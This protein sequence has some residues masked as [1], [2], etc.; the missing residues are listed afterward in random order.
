MGSHRWAK[1]I[2]TSEKTAKMADFNYFKVMKAKKMRNSIT[3][4][5][6]KKFQGQLSLGTLASIAKAVTA[7]AAVIIPTNTVTP[8][9]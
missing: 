2:E 4:N 6:I 8:W 3:E 7:A 1:K 5:E 9:T